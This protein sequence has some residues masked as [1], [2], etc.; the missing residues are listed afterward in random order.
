MYSN[1]YIQRDKYVCVD[2]MYI[3]TSIMQPLLPIFLYPQYKNKFHLPLRGGRE[4]IEIRETGYVIEIVTYLTISH[5]E[6]LKPIRNVVTKKIL[7][8]GG[9][10]D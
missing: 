1:I 4:F 5:L 7:L 10:A 8:K 9:V 3:K 2:S 6:Y